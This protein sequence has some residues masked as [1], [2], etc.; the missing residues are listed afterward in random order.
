MNCF[1]LQKICQE[2]RL[3]FCATCLPREPRLAKNQRHCQK[4]RALL[5][6]SLGYNELMQLKVMVFGIHTGDGLLFTIYP[7][8]YG[9]LTCR[10]ALSLCIT[11]QE[12]KRTQ[13][14]P[15]LHRAK[16]SRSWSGLQSG[17]QSWS[18]SRRCT[19]LHGTF[20]VHY[21]VIVTSQ[22]INIWIKWSRS[23]S[24]SSVNTGQ[25]FEI[26]IWVILLHANQFADV[27]LS[28]YNAFEGIEWDAHWLYCYLMENSSKFYPA[29]QVIHI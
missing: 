3:H 18:R 21:S 12:K 10:D 5:T 13:I 19:C 27:D 16:F 15:S 25:N 23:W 1:F 14:M 9:K 2:C 17:L 6:G 7:T 28:F 29:F 8:V 4:C 24:R 22:S 11:N 20:I 26:M